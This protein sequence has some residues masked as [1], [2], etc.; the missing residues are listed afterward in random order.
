MPLSVS[1]VIPCYN[2]QATISELLEAIYQ[3]TYPR[4]ETEVIIADGLSEDDTRDV[5]RNFQ[6]THPELDV[7]IVDNSARSIPS[8]VNTAIQA[9]RG[10]NIVRMD[11]QAGSAKHS[12]RAEKQRKQHN[13]HNDVDWDIQ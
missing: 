6:D 7:H 8:A 2:E 9:A 10:E 4:S 5:I 12:L 11:A 1:I 13:P 3:Q